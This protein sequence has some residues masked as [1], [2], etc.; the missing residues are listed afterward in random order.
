MRNLNWKR[1]VIWI[2]F[3]VGSVGRHYRSIY[4]PTLGRYID[5]VSVEY[6]S[7]ID[8]TSVEYRPILRPICVS[9]DTV[10]VLS[11]LGR[12]LIDTL[13]IVCR[14]FTDTRSIP[15]RYSDQVPVD[16]RPTKSICLGRYVGRSLPDDILRYLTFERRYKRDFQSI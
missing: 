2:M 10:L 14:Y 12:Y 13:P 9:A 5:R 4:R 1:Y 16:T 15:Y 8:R 3:T 11:T 6:Q 7:S